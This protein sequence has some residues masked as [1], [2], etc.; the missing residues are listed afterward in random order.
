MPP[1]VRFC[2]VT[3]PGLMLVYG[4]LRL[5]DGLDGDRHNGPAWDVGHVAFFAAV[6]LFAVLAVAL[7]RINRPWTIAVPAVLAT[8]FG[9]GCFLWVITGDLSESFQN[10]YPLPDSLDLLG[11][12]LFQIGLLVL[13]VQLVIARELPAWSP[14]AVLIGFAVIPVSLDLLP[15]GSVLVGAGLLPLARW[16]HTFPAASKGSLPQDQ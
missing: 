6:V 7:A 8:L 9:A 11:P 10:A 3:A 4:L 14:V 5:V 15:L 12:L 13:L 1:L 16:A 2:A